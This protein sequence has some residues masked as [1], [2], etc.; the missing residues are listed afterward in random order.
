MA[1]NHIGV[2]IV[3]FVKIYQLN[4]IA[5]N[6]KQKYNVFRTNVDGLNSYDI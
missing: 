2:Q 5:T 6:R 4:T 1:Y 3:K